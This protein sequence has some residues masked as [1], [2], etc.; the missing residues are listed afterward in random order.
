[1]R[2][3]IET[4]DR[5][6]SFPFPSRL[7]FNT[8]SVWGYCKANDHPLSLH[9]AHVLCKKLLRWK[10]DYPHMPLLEVRTRDAYILFRL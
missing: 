4:D 5:H 9:A 8:L 6:I 7:A 2:M 1:M 10:K 3:L